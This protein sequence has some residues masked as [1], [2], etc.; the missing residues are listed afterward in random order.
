MRAPGVRGT[1]RRSRPAPALGAALLLAASVACRSDE[2]GTVGAVDHAAKIDD[3]V[4]AFHDA[5]QLNGS[6]LVAENGEVIYEKGVGW[7]NVA[8]E[9]PNTP[10]TKHRIGS[11]TKQFT[12]ALVLQLAEEGKI[13]L[14]API[15]TYLP[16]YPEPQG[17]KVTVH[18]LLNHTSGIPSYTGLP[19]F[20]AM[21]RDPYEPDELIAVV[22]SLPLEFEPGTDWAYNNSGYFLLGRILE[23]VTGEDYADLL[24]E[25][26]LAPVGLDDSGYD[27]YA[28]I[29]SREAE[30]YRNALTGLEH[31]AYLDTSL[32]YAAGMMY[33]TVRDLYA[34]D[35]ALYDGATPF[36]EMGTKELWFTPGLQD[37]AYG[38]H[39]ADVQ[40]GEEG[41]TVRVI[42]HGG[43]ING[44]STAFR[45]Y[46][47]QQNLVVVI[48][49]AEG[50]S[51]AVADQIARVLYDQPVE[52]P[53]PEIARVVVSTFEQEGTEAG[54][55]E[56]RR[57]RAEAPDAYDFSE[58]QLNTLGYHFLGKGET[59][60]AIAVFRLNVEQYPDAFNTYDS[61][62]EAYREAGQ[63]DLAIENYRRSVELNPGNAN[64]RRALVEMGVELEE[65]EG[66]SLPVETLER[67]VGDYEIQPGFELTV[68]REGTRLF[69]Q[70]TGQPRFEIFA[71][72]ETRFYVKEFPAQ[73]EF[74]VEASGPASSAILFQGGRETPAK[75]V[76]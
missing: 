67:Y 60:T 8:W 23:N 35:R 4:T 5:G 64:G 29:E 41:P 50:N 36:G 17:S 52:A 57:L 20:G 61:L 70:A 16:G 75:R 31:A 40:V 71:Q 66:L 27:D 24:R 53:K 39:V 26:L 55:V 3:V 62:G 7:A 38:W 11:V 48:D 25:R 47:G 32:P 72:S 12:S 51:G 13:E 54:I 33:S 9:I 58:R 49:N 22:S 1:R 14:Q 34:W 2:P 19:D 21:V 43:G 76:E 10:D 65:A 56:Y 59:E 63:I 68:M 37:Y 28:G 44:F 15:R 18:H 45:R 74:V 69:T 6:V 46:P 73:I 42:E 30:G